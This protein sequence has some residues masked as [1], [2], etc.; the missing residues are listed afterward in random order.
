MLYDCSLISQPAM[1][2]YTTMTPFVTIIPV[3]SILGYFLKS[4]AISEHSVPSEM[5]LEKKNPSLY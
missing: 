5:S 3:S 1:R 4:R 2:N